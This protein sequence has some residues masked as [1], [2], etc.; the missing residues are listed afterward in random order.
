MPNKVFGKPEEDVPD[1]KDDFSD[2]F[3]DALENIDEGDYE[4]AIEKLEKIK[5]KVF[6]EI[7]ESDERQEMISLIDTLIAYL[8]TL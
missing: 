3:D 6:E 8:E 1:L 2:L 4:G 7:L 5:Q